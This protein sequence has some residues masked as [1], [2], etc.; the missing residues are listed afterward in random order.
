MNR[1]AAASETHG[2]ASSMWRAMK[3]IER[4][5]Q[6]AERHGK[7][8]NEFQLIKL[9]ELFRYCRDASRAAYKVLDHLERPERKPRK[10]RRPRPTPEACHPDPERWNERGIP[11]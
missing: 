10:P 3:N 11:R 7:P 5:V 9:R 2:I 8:F 6:A 4:M 1:N